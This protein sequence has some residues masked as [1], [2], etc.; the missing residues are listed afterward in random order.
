MVGRVFPKDQDLDPLSLG[1]G[2][3]EHCVSYAEASWMEWVEGSCGVPH[4]SLQCR[5]ETV[6]WGLLGLGGVKLVNA[7][8]AAPLL[9]LWVET[10]RRNP[11]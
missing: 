8:W 6:G 4:P 3:G 7:R 5:V 11:G 10:Q 9:A 2:I 1:S